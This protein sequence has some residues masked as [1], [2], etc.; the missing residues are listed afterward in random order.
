MRRN[1][2]IDRNQPGIV[3]TLRQSGCSVQTLAPVGQGCPDLLVGRAGVNYLLEIKDEDQPPSGRRLT[4]D[5]VKWHGQ[6]KGKVYVVKNEDEAL[7]A[8]GAIK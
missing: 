2:K 1:A 7:R 3:Q 6:W 5:Q 4:T 8:V